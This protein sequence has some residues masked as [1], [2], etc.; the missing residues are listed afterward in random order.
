MITI[1]DDFKLGDHVL[2][3]DLNGQSQIMQVSI[4]N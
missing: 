2:H 1:K 3:L 4:I